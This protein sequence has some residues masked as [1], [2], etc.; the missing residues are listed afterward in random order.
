[1]RYI[2]DLIFD[3]KKMKRGFI[4]AYVV[5]DRCPKWDFNRF[6]AAMKSKG[7]R[8]LGAQTTED[9]ISQFDKIYNAGLVASKKIKLARFFED[10]DFLEQ[11][12]SLH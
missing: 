4:R 1:M 9:Y 6:K 10:K 3:S 2:N 12:S 11:P 8:L 7:A 5:A